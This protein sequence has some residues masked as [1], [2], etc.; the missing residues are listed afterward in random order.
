MD[1]NNE[2]MVEEEQINNEQEN[3]FGGT[4]HEKDSFDEND[5]VREISDSFL[6]Y[7]MN[8]F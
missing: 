8:W 3:E 2:K 5:I 4:F 7:S 1:E 6:D